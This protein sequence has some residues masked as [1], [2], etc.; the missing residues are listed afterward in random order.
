MSLEQITKTVENL[1]K[2]WSEFKKTND[3]R[4]KQIESKGSADPITEEKL[5]KI[6]KSIEQYNAEM[7]KLSKIVARGT[8]SDSKDGLTPEKELAQKSFNKFLTKGDKALTAEELKAFSIG[9]GGDGGFLLTP[10]VRE[11]IDARLYLTSPMR[12]I[13]T[14]VQTQATEVDWPIR[15]AKSS[16]GWVGEQTSR[17]NT[18]TG[19]PFGMLK[20]PVKEVYANP[21]VTQRFL[22]TV[23]NAAEVVMNFITEDL[24]LEENTAFVTGDGNEKPKGFLNDYQVS[25]SYSASK[26]QAIKSGSNGDFDF[27]DVID[28]YYTLKSPYR[29]N[30]TFLANNSIFKTIRKFKDQNDQ[31]LWQPSLVAGSPSTI[32][33]RP[34]I[35]A[36]DMPDASTGSLSLAFGDFKKGYVIVDG[37]QTSVL[38]DPY[39]NKPF[40][41]FYAVKD[42]GGSVAVAEAIKLLQLAS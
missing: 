18:D 25:T 20:I 32:L 37:K 34:A 7:D 26:L 41:N 19:Q 12:Q 38:R 6:N 8:L 4:L 30:A 36:N 3:E 39:S 40:V 42:T 14:V 17:P 1:N 21:P 16:S 13:C 11:L 31:Y 15:V 29:A 33:G 28:L 22:D 35:E 27:D 2:D 5:E 9:S 23:S 24:M 10:D